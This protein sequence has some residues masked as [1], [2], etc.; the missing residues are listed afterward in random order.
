MPVPDAFAYEWDS[1]NN[2]YR[3]GVTA[4]VRRGKRSAT[5]YA[6]FRETAGHYPV[7]CGACLIWAE[8]PEDAKNV[9]KNAAAR[10]A[11]EKLDCV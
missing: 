7:R 8:G 10:R 6:Y 9:A 3:N 4:T 5:G 2:D 1:E 11:L